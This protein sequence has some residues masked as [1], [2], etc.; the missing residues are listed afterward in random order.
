[1]LKYIKSCYSYVCEMISNRFEYAYGVNKNQLE[2]E[3]NYYCKMTDGG[4]VIKKVEEP[5]V[6]PTWGPADPGR[7]PKAHMTPSL[8]LSPFYFRVQRGTRQ[9]KREEV[10]EAVPAVGGA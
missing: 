7:A 3:N 10:V 9:I 2:Q 6:P 1:M 5:T 4:F 8:F